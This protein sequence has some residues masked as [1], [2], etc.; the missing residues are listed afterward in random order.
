MT[1]NLCCLLKPDNIMFNVSHKRLLGLYLHYLYSM[2]RNPARII[3]I[4]IWPGIEVVLFAILASSQLY[5]SQEGARVTLNILT[6]IVYW[7][8]T[9]RIIQETTAQFIDDF[10]SKNIQNLLLTP[11][12]LTELI[13]GITAASLTKILI[14]LSVLFFAISFIY[15][16]FLLAIG[17]HV[18]QW[19]ILLEMVGVSLSLYAIAAICIFGER[20]GFIG[21]LLST[22]LQIFSLVFYE[23]TALPPILQRVS[24]AAPSSYVFE[25]IRSFPIQHQSLD[26]ALWLIVGY[27]IVGAVCVSLA[28][29]IAKRFG[30]FIKI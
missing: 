12:N 10:T 19:V 5:Q 2:R 20:I 23:R 29:H 6:G 24:Y 21:W 13:M 28:F 27:I 4:M 30:T 22:I 17:P 9:A 14:S 11:I 15:P 1:E 26:L 7:N 3:E 18:F 25:S 16:S 8:C